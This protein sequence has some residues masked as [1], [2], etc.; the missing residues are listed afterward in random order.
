[1]LIIE[2]IVQFYG[3]GAQPRKNIDDIEEAARSLA[4]ASDTTDQ[5][6]SKQ[7]LKEEKS[8]KNNKK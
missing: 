5:A 2:E 6:I 8:D 4:F 3:T 1:M 7:K